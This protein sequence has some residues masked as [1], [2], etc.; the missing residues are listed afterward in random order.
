M[1]N[2]TKVTDPMSLTEIAVKGS[3]QVV[4][5]EESNEPIGM[6]S[7]CLLYYRSRLFFL[8]V[9]HVT[10][11]ENVSITIE[12]NKIPHNGKSENYCVGGMHYYDLY[13]A[14]Q[15]DKL[16][17]DELLDDS[18]LESIETLDFA[19]AEIPELPMVIQK[20]IDF[21]H[22][23]IVPE[24]TK[25]VIPENGLESLPNSDETLLFFG[26]INGKFKN[27]ILQRQPKLTVDCEYLGDQDRFYKLR[28]PQTIEDASEYEGTSGAPVF[29]TTGNFIG[30][31]S[32][33]FEGLPF[34]YIF[35]NTEIKKTTRL[36]Y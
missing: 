14:E 3:Y 33:G 36:L 25:I 28:L 12:T 35:K 32:Y 19:F 20:E 31:I 34:M 17:S 23:G 1:K 22:H 6:G 9:A 8:T 29:D 27:G 5:T 26:S 18:K 21:K 11:E 16:K 15:L 2:L 4:V 24:G 30:L 7:G 13:D 10:N